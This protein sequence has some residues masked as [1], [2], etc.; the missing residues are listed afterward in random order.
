MPLSCCVSTFFNTVRLRIKVSLHP[1]LFFP[2]FHMWQRHDY[3]VNALWSSWNWVW[4]HSVVSVHSFIEVDARFV[5]I[6]DEDLSHIF[7][8]IKMLF[9]SWSSRRLQVKITFLSYH[10]GTKDVYTLN[11]SRKPCLDPQISRSML[12]KVSSFPHRKSH[13]WGLNL[14]TLGYQFSSY[15]LIKLSLCNQKFHSIRVVLRF[16]LLVSVYICICSNPS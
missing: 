1:M 10:S 7:T 3:F 5:N 2:L 9:G 8:E 4:N 16:R 12:K 11:I 15:L 13:P 6:Y 14:Q